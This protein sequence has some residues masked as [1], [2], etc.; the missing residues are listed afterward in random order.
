[1]SIASS[2]WSFFA[3]ALALALASAAQPALAAEEGVAG[4]PDA[5]REASRICAG[6]HGPQGDAT[7]PRY[8]DLAG[9]NAVYLVRSMTAYR[10][11]G[12]QDPEM[13]PM[14]ANLSDRQIRD[15]AVFYSAQSPCAD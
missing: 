12:R 8:P 10:D 9:Q 5:G 15:L 13:S 11:G 1:M 4:D 2:L 7:L 14:A 6:C 3:P